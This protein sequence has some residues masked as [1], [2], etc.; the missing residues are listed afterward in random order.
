M[1]TGQPIT[2]QEVN[3]TQPFTV[4]LEAQQW[5]VIMA[6]LNEAPYRHA[7]PVIQ[8][9]NQQLQEAAAATQTAQAAGVPMR[10]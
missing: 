10:H 2:N 9:L 5:N 3:A 4:T 1:M 6:A 7:A 8:T